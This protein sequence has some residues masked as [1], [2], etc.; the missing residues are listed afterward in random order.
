MLRPTLVLGLALFLAGA[1][2]G[3]PLDAAAPDMADSGPGS[4][5]GLEADADGGPQGGVDDAG[6]PAPDAATTGCEEKCTGA[7]LTFCSDATGEALELDCGALDARCGLLNEA[8]GLDCLLPQ[9]AVCHPG[10]ADGA[11]RCD[12]EGA[13][14]AAVHCTSGLCSTNA[15][16]ADAGPTPPGLVDG[17]GRDATTEESCLGCPS[18]GSFPFLAAFAFFGLR[19]RRG[20]PF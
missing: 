19:R 4:D 7:I 18:S 14:G 1:D 12:P 8:W 17:T 13:G 3:S 5:A 16:A 6:N 20:R 15:P 9:G 11:T 10:Y 2:G